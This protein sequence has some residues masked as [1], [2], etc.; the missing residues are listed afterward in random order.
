MGG[1]THS[2]GISPAAPQGRGHRNSEREDDQRHHQF[3]QRIATLMRA[4][5]HDVNPQVLV[6]DLV[7]SCASVMVQPV[8]VPDPVAVIV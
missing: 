6:A 7:P 8:K 1:L 2:D 5:Y 3:D 4:N